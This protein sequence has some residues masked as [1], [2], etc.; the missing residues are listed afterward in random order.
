MKHNKTCDSCRILK[1]I[2]E[3]NAPGSSKCKSCCAIKKCSNCLMVKP[4]DQ[5]R[6]SK[7]RKCI[8]C[9]TNLYKEYQAKWHQENKQSIKEKRSTP[10]G[11]LKRKQ[12]NR[13]YFLRHHD[14]VLKANKIRSQSEAYRQ[15]RNEQLRNRIKTDPMYRLN[16]NVRNG[17]Y[18]SLLRNKHGKHWEL[19]VGYTLEELKSHIEK[20][21]VDGMN[22]DNY[23]EWVID[24]IRPIVSFN[25]TDFHCQD[26]KEC[27]QLSNL[28]P[29]WY[30]DNAK[31]KRT[32]QNTVC[33]PLGNDL[34][35]LII[36]QKCQLVN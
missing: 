29:L 19:L 26:F 12:H 15:R 21:F 31:K 7:G 35:P 20:Q 34:T 23:G 10:K 25:I 2:S 33:S 28:R 24:H 5:F 30:L 32:R 6:T 4:P 22:W 1:P 3:F 27:W 17:I 9:I 16:K 8:E 36:L 13:M 11:K 18:T 14:E